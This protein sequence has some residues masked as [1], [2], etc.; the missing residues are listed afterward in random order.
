MK[1]ICATRGRLG[2]NMFCLAG[3][4]KI[5]KEK[6]AEIVG[7]F[8][9]DHYAVQSEYIR[10]TILRKIPYLN[11][12][13]KNGIAVYPHEPSAYH[14]EP[15][16]FPDE[17]TIIMDC[18]SQDMRFI[19]K[20]ICYN[21]F[22][23]YDSIKDEI[24]QTYG[25]LSNYVCVNVRRG[26]FLGLGWLGFKVLNKEFIIKNLEKY[27][28]KSKVLMVSDDIKWCKDNFKDEGFIFADKPCTNKIEMDLY[29]QTVCGQ[30]NLISNS[31]FSWWG[32]YLNPSSNK[33]VVFSSPWYAKNFLNGGNC[34]IPDD[35]IKVE[36]S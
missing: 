32:A 25:D 9:N 35:W 22:G 29:L 28:D 20:D 30:G 18:L 12:F 36:E 24:L 31:T 16:I 19:D 8:H 34:I 4:Y 10:N 33:K 17:D 13:D 21:L 23:I 27:F 1:I 2:N 11:G 26:D 14:F 7:W 15:F 6:N 3:A 5:A